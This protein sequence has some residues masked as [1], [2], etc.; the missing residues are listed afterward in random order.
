MALSSPVTL[1][2]GSPLDWIWVGEEETQ[3]E[4]RSPQCERGIGDL[5]SQGT[6]EQDKGL[7]GQ[8]PSNVPPCVTCSLL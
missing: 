4:M 1:G 8:G 3:E 6:R 5:P 7:R 2:L